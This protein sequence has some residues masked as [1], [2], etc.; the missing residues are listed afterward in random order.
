MDADGGADAVT[1]RQQ[2][3]DGFEQ[4][5]FEEASVLLVGAGGL[6]SEIAEGLV[7]KGVGGLVVCDED[8]VA[9]SNLARQRFF[10]KD[11]GENKA[12]ALAEN[13]V[14][15]GTRGTDLVAFPHH[16]EDLVARG[17]DFAPDVVVCAPDNDAARLAVAEHF[18]GRVPVVT[19]GLDPEAV[20]GYA[21]VQDGR[22]CFRCYRPDAGGGGA[23][24]GAPAVKDPATVVA[25][26]ALYAKKLKT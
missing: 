19:T 22:A 13:L 16:F 6:G 10:A 25:G 18:H 24:P 15:E 20:R 4:A 11:V 23:C 2:R 12:E 26:L 7:R 1:D 5:V 9:A 14:P 3:V 8:V 17:V 21:F